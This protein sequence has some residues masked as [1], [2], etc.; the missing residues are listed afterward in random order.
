MAV[1]MCPGTCSLLTLGVHVNGPAL[2]LRRC[3]KRRPSAVG[4]IGGVG[5]GDDAALRRQLPTCQAGV[6]HPGATGFPL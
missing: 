2:A 1:H 6:R 3:I 4:R 5:G